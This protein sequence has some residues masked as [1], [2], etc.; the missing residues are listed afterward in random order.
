MRYL[1]LI[2]S[3][4][5][6][7]VG[8]KKDIGIQKSDILSSVSLEDNKTILDIPLQSSKQTVLDILLSKYGLYD[9]FNKSD[10]DKLLFQDVLIDSQK[11]NLYFLFANNSLKASTI[12]IKGD[13]LEDATDYFLYLKG[14]IG[15]KF[16]DNMS[17]IKE[18][19]RH[20]IYFIPNNTDPY[21]GIVLSLEESKKEV[22]LVISDVKN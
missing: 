7:I 1:Y 9:R 2:F 18:S 15:E 14:Y 4:F 13:N 5:I 16:K 17:M 11:S 20:I 21:L 10:E 6:F 22:Q 3:L 8:C 12:I 19:H